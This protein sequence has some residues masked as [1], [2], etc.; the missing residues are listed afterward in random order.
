MP[1]KK[2]ETDA[3]FAQRFERFGLDFNTEWFRNHYNHLRLSWH[4]L[5]ISDKPITAIEYHFK[6]YH[7][8][9]NAYLMYNPTITRFWAYMVQ[10]RMGEHET[11]AEWVEA[12]EDMLNYSLMFD[13][14]SGLV[15]ASDKSKRNYIKPDKKGIK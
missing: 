14:Y 4:Y 13:Y 3:E 5:K 9:F 15:I 8:R 12:N 6:R 7:R 11:F 1:K 10:S 2:Q